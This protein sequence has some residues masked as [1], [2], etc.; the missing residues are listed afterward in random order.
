MFD[1]FIKIKKMKLYTYDYNYIKEILFG[2]M[3]FRKEMDNNNKKICRMYKNFSSFKS[4]INNLMSRN[5]SI[6]GINIYI[7]PVNMVYFAGHAK[8]Y[9]HCGNYR[10]NTR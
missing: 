2:Y 9:G 10:T 8:F 4:S 7:R 1:N 5:K 6:L 3:Y